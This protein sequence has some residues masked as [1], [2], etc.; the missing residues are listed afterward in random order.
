V[1]VCVCVCGNDSAIVMAITMMVREATISRL[2]VE[3][4]PLFVCEPEQFDHRGLQALEWRRKTLRIFV[5]ELVREFLTD[6]VSPTRCPSTSF[7][8]SSSLCECAAWSVNLFN[9]RRN[10]VSHI[11]SPPSWKMPTMIKC[12]TATLFAARKSRTC[13]SP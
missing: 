5:P 7:I 6:Q 11:V 3:M 4:D 13:W 9:V 1:C 8:F 10:F 2:C 12:L